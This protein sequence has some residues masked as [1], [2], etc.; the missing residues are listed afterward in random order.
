MNQGGRHSALAASVAAALAKQKYTESMSAIDTTKR[1]HEGVDPSP[2]K[3][4]KGG[5]GEPDDQSKAPSPT[6]DGICAVAD[7]GPDSGTG[8]AAGSAP[9]IDGQAEAQTA[10]Q[11]ER[12]QTDLARS[13]SDQAD[14]FIKTNPS[15]EQLVAQLFEVL[16]TLGLEPPCQTLACTNPL[17]LSQCTGLGLYVCV[18]I[19]LQLDQYMK[20]DKEENAKNLHL[21]EQKV[22]LKQAMNLLLAQQEEVDTAIRNGAFNEP[23]YAK[24]RAD[25]TAAKKLY[26]LAI[27]NVDHLSIIEESHTTDD[28]PQYP[29]WVSNPG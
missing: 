20:K 22:E 1:E 19:T 7:S 2:N 9:A 4:F 3:R 26:E 18:K 27:Q 23:K 15:K 24:Q 5:E 21:D 16:S 12:G 11:L 14:E 6:N 8:D 17:R 28:D 25:A 13:L 29:N 10:V